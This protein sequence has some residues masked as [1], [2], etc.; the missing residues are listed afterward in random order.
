MSWRR[1]L[2]LGAAESFFRHQATVHAPEV[3]RGRLPW[4]LGSLLILIVVLTNPWALLLA[5]NE[6]TVGLGVCLMTIL[7]GFVSLLAVGFAAERVT[8]HLPYACSIAHWNSYRLANKGFTVA[9]SIASAAFQVLLLM[10]L[11]THAVLVT[12]DVRPIGESSGDSPSLLALFGSLVLT[13]AVVLLWGSR[14]PLRILA[15]TA[16]LFVLLLVPLAL[17]LDKHTQANAHN[18]LH[19]ASLFGDSLQRYQRYLV[20][21]LIAFGTPCLLGF[22]SRLLQVATSVRRS[23][24]GY[25]FLLAGVIFLI[26]TPVLLLWLHFPSP[27]GP[28][29][30][31]FRLAL[32]ALLTAAIALSLYALAADWATLRFGFDDGFNVLDRIARAEDDKQPEVASVLGN[33]GRVAFVATLVGALLVDAVFWVLTLLRLDGTA[34]KLLLPG[35][36][37]IALSFGPPLYLSLWR[38]APSKSWISSLLICLVALVLQVFGWL[39]HEFASGNFQFYF[40]VT[41]LPLFILAW[42]V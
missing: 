22:D 33:V 14:N 21:F 4:P 35:A 40:F 6:K 2:S 26:I 5:V 42:V 20:G 18:L 31:T 24:L 23:H 15:C 17:A 39:D 41:S 8:R 1:I 7:W 34:D 27:A 38:R 29:A 37:V 36:A 11:V 16:G 9:V 19:M 3:I 25:C 13:I 30:T 28:A 32:L 12:H 10:V